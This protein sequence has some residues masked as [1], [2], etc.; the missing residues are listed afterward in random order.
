[1]II[2]EIR[3]S[4]EFLEDFKKMPKNI[5][6]KTIENLEKLKEN[7][8]YPSLRLH[9]LKGKLEGLWSISL[10]KAYRITFEPLENGDILLI[11]IGTHSI[12]EK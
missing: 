10:N 1:M 8:F 9:P 2:Q 12:Y 3:Y 6:E 7:P 5:Q 4:K 11:S